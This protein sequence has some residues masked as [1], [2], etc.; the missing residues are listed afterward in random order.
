VFE[1]PGECSAR[2][3]DEEGNEIH[4]STVFSKG[5]NKGGVLLG[6]FF[7]LDVAA[8]VYSEADFHDDEGVMFP[9]EI[10]WI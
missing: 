5:G 4:P 1:G 7:D 2:M 6:L 9:V 8:E 3:V 10:D